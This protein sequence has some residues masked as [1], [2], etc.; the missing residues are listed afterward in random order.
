M[1]KPVDQETLQVFDRSLRRCEANPG[2][3]DLF[4]ETFLASSPK[5]R[6]KFANTNFDRQKRWL[7]ASFYLILLASEDP[8][9]GPERYLQHLAERHS[10]RDLDIGSDLYDLWLD[11]LLAVVEECDPEFD[12]AIASAWEQVME[13]G[14]DYL[15]RHYR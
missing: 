3:L 4:Y 8:E 12:E 2:F 1:L 15:V 13:I 5:V 9:H 10:V 7:H 14:I 11:S 6:E